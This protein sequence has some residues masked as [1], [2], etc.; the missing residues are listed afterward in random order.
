VRSQPLKITTSAGKL[1]TATDV[2]LEEAPAPTIGQ[3]NFEDILPQLPTEQLLLS[4][5]LGGENFMDIEVPAAVVQE[6]QE[7]GAKTPS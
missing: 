4:L 5:P 1:L 6:W 7:V 3:Y 2:F